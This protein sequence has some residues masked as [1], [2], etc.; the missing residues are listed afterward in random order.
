MA[1]T[2]DICG[3][4]PRAKDGGMG[5][6]RAVTNVFRAGGGVCVSFELASSAM[7]FGPV[8]PMICAAC[9]DKLR[10]HE[11]LLASEARD[12]ERERQR[13]LAAERDVVDVTPRRID[14]ARR[15][16]LLGAGDKIGGA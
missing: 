8:M 11:M 12:A 1:L 6:M 9:W 10:L 14:G 13:E 3:K 4:G 5:S 15:T 7:M 2:C 16:R